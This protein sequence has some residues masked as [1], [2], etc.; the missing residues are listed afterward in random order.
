MRRGS[1]GS[2]VKELQRLLRA[3]NVKGA[4]RPTGYYG[5]ATERAVKR[6]QTKHKLGADGVVGPKTWAAIRRAAN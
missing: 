1:Q 6:F 2:R 4:P 3:L 5:V